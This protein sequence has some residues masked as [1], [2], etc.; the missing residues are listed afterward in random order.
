MQTS[1]G[2]AKSTATTPQS[3]PARKRKA[4]GAVGDEN[5]QGDVVL[6]EGAMG[7]GST[8]NHGTIMVDTLGAATQALAIKTPRKT[9]T[10]GKRVKIEESN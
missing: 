6:G 8:V 3:A 9:S 7:D 1:R 10:R 4:A 2:R 5:D